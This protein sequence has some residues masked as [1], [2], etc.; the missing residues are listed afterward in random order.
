MSI[1]MQYLSLK[2]KRLIVFLH[3]YSRV[4]IVASLGSQSRLIF[5]YTVISVKPFQIACASK[6]RKRKCNL[7]IQRNSSILPVLY[8]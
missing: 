7:L 5:F 4:Y 2:N 8:K 1:L 6:S 3:C